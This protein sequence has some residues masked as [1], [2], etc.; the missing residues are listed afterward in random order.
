MSTASLADKIL[1]IFCAVILLASVS[2]GGSLYSMGV[3]SNK[4]WSSPLLPSAHAMPEKN[5]EN[6]AS[7]NMT[8]FK[9]FFKDVDKEKFPEF[10][11][12]N[13]TKLETKNKKPNGDSEEVDVFSPIGKLIQKKQKDSKN[14]NEGKGAQKF[15]DTFTI[16]CHKI[17]ALDNGKSNSTHKKLNVT[18]FTSFKIKPMSEDKRGGDKNNTQSEWGTLEIRNT[19]LVSPLDL[20]YRLTDFSEAEVFSS[21]DT[22]VYDEGDFIYVIGDNLVNNTV[23]ALLYG[24]LNATGTPLIGFGEQE[25]YTDDGN[26]MFDGG[27]TIYLDSDGDNQVNNTSDALLAG[28]EKA[29][30]TSLIGF[31]VQEKHTDDGNGMFE[32]NESIY[33]DAKTPVDVVDKNMIRLFANYDDSLTNKTVMTGDSDIGVPI[34]NLPITIKY[35]DSNDNG[36]FSV[37]ETVY[38]DNDGDGIVSILD[39][40]LANYETLN[41]VSDT[42]KVGYPLDMT[43]FNNFKNT[44]SPANNGTYNSNTEKCDYS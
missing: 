41:L 40:R 33:F 25:K 43:D 28:P 24:P 34:A 1:S 5:C 38:R 9:E 8:S 27:E 37:N 20:G 29:D 19:G 13:N 22:S 7:S 15:K 10:A 6:T 30:G 31:G 21:S 18:T 36:Q 42:T 14:V 4:D 11:V 35:Y 39:N 16:N 17:L 44:C 2:A 32:S 12:K 26:E 23:D 3:E